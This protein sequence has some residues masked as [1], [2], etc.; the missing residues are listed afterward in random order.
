MS[1]DVV[2]ILIDENLKEKNRTVDIFP[3]ILRIE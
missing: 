2:G 1:K 3:S